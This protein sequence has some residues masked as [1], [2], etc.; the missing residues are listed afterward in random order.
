MI[1]VEYWIVMNV[2]GRD[3]MEMLVWI[4]S[5]RVGIVVVALN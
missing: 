3:H 4:I 5:V 2:V 1:W